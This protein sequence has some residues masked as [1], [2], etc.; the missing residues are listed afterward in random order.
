MENQILISGV[1]MFTAFWAVLVG[2]STI[3]PQGISS[4][5][6]VHLGQC[7]IN[8]LYL[9]LKYHGIDTPLEDLYTHIQTD[10][11]NNVSLKQLGDYAK[12]KGLNVQYMEDPGSGDVQ[13]ILQRKRSVIL[14]YKITLPDNSI[15]KHIVALIK[16]D[17]RIILLDYPNSRQ[18]VSLEDLSFIDGNSEGMLILSPKPMI[19]HLRLAGICL[20]VCGFLGI[21]T[22]PMIGK[23]KNEKGASVFMF[24]S[25]FLQGRTTRE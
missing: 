9:C 2:A 16:P 23:N 21:M 5:E 6:N 1:G 22:F 17:T 13:R 7:G 20:I 4:L 8:S 10:S 18:E 19:N 14:Q 3:Q 15:Y 24:A 25:H 11:E 12:R